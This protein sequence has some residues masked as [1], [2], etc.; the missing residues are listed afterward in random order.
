MAEWGGLYA[1]ARAAG[2]SENPRAG[3]VRGNVARCAAP[4]ESERTKE[5]R[6]WRKGSLPFLRAGARK[7]DKAANARFYLTIQ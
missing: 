6:A 1:K 3:R 4:R 5:C 7:S 2:K